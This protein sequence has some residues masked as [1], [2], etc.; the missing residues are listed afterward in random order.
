MPDESA[1]RLLGA[2]PGELPNTTHRD[3]IRFVLLTGFR[4]EEAAALRWSE[5]DFDERVVRLPASRAKARRRLDL[6]MSDLVFQLLH[7][8]SE[9][10]R[11]GDWVFPANS[12]TGYIAE[13]KFALKQIADKTGVRVMPHSLRRTFATV[14]E[15]SRLTFTE[16]KM[17][18]NH[19]TG[20]VTS[21][22]IQANVERLRVPV[23]TVADRFKVL[24]GIATA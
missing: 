10:G 14:A 23:Q 20:D 22:Y 1:W 18:L 5:V 9:R 12:K 15:A 7:A 16:V 17:L 4:R 2:L 13:P 24:C 8:R 21:G 3:Y 19:A 11:E 6:P